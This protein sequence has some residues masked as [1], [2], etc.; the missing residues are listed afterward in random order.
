MSVFDREDVLRPAVGGGLQ[1]SSGATILARL[2]IDVRKAAI[3][4]R[5]VRS[6]SVDGTQLLSLDVSKAMGRWGL[7]GNVGGADGA[8]AIMRETLQEM[9]AAPLPPDTLKLGRKLVGTRQ[10]SS[11]GVSCSFDDGSEEEFDLVVGCDGI[12][13]VVKKA[14]FPDAP[15]PQYSG[16]KVALAIAPRGT[17]PSGT[18][19]EFHQWLGDG[20]Y[21]LSASYGGGASGGSDML[22]LCYS[23][24]NPGSENAGWDSDSLRDSTL[25]RMRAARMPDEVLALAEAGERFYETSVNYRN[26]QLKWYKGGAVLAG[27]AAHAMPPFLG[28]GANQAICDGFALA[29][30]LKQVGGLHPTVES[31]LAAYSG[32][33]LF[34]TTRLLLNSRFLGFL[35]TQEGKGAEF[36]DAFFTFTGK[37]GIAEAVFIDGAS[38]R[39]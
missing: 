17:R 13:S 6:R 37:V 36:R 3:P 5:S 1:L 26:P 18:E 11:G 8:F 39:V 12:S 28:Q 32:K 34:P 20:A 9:L 10:L 38:V 35:E 31:A 29:K 21:C 25:A 27:D 14:A 4:L 7:L 2:G 22:A 33:R 24:A 16:V 15:Q 23:D 19:G 30:E